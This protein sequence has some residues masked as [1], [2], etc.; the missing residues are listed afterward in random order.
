MEGKNLERKSKT[1]E[2]TDPFSPGFFLSHSLWDLI[3][4]RNPHLEASSAPGG[5]SEG[6]NSP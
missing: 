5:F 3:T 4:D 2:Y 6:E 1:Y